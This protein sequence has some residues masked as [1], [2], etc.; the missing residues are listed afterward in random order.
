MNKNI[1]IFFFKIDDESH[2]INSII[3]KK[4]NMYT[5]KRF[6][7]KIKKIYFFKFLVTIYCLKIL[8]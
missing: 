4:K 6:V 5:K 8:I 1:L 7:S 3:F 2:G